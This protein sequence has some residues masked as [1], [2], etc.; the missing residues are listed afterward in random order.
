ML[1]FRVT[2]KGRR[3]AISPCHYDT[4]LPEHP[5]SLAYRPKRIRDFLAKAYRF[6]RLMSR[7]DDHI[8]DWASA[9]DVDLAKLD[10]VARWA[11]SGHVILKMV[12]PKG[13]LDPR[14]YMT[15][16]RYEA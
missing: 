15:H 4:R 7:V 5:L 11:R 12:P 13:A 16:Y 6:R 9:W 3:S 14:R 2:W 8:R 1:T 10:V